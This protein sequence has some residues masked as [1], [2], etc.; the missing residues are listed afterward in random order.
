MAASDITCW[1][2]QARAHNDLSRPRRPVKDAQTCK[3]SCASAASAAQGALICHR[4]LRQVGLLIVSEPP[5]RQQP[6]V[7]RKLRAAPPFRPLEVTN[8]RLRQHKVLRRS[9]GAMREAIA[10]AHLLRLLLRRHLDRPCCCPQCPKVKRDHV[11]LQLRA[12]QKLHRRSTTQAHKQACTRLGLRPAPDALGKL[13]CPWRA[14]FRQLQVRSQRDYRKRRSSR[15][16]TNLALSSCTYDLGWAAQRW[17]RPSRLI[18]NSSPT[19]A[20][21]Q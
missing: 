2:Y 8:E 20:T 15:T 18:R 6:T 1:A 14:R 4:E 13:H 12:L 19:L 21:R 3:H 11:R 17:A 9:C 10:R 5:V 16:S 7:R